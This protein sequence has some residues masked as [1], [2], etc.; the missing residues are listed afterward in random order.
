M[1][2][3]IHFADAHERA[4]SDSGME[5]ARG[6]ATAPQWSV[7]VIA[8]NEEATIAK[9][10]ESVVQALSGRSYELIFVDSASTDRTVSVAARFPAKI[11]CI[12]P[13]NRLSP[14]LGRHTGSLHTRGEWV[15]FLDGD[16]TLNGHW[17]GE[18]EQVL[19]EHPGLGGIA[20]ERVQVLAAT[21][22]HPS[23]CYYYP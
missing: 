14:S 9:C 13:S 8:R 17:V 22:S 20:G 5:P 19:T 3:N 7:V 11:I 16:C 1:G 4:G 15:L 12:P 10:L 18:A 21:R 23:A 2:L 6:S